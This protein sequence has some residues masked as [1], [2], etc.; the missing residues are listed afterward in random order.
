[1]IGLCCGDDAIQVS[2][3]EWF[4]LTFKFVELDSVAILRMAGDDVSADDDGI[5]VEP[6]SGLQAR[7]DGQRHH[8]FDVASGAA[9]VGGGE[10]H[11]DGVAFLANFDLHLNGEAG[12][13]AAVALG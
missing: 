1:M 5:R 8:E 11:G 2:A 9:E 3:Q 6:E 12:M 13:L 10:A 7:A 4:G